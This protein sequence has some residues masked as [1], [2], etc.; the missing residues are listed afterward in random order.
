[1]TTDFF[2]GTD[3]NAAI[4]IQRDGSILTGGF[5]AHASGQ[6][7]FALA[8]YNG[9]TFDV[10]VQDDTTGGLF[11]FSSV[12]GDYIFNECQKKGLV[13]RGRGKLNKT[14]CSIDLKDA[15][16]DRRLDA[17]F[18]SCTNSGSARITTS[19]TF[20]IADADTRKGICAC[21]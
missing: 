17:H 5:A 12:T 14:A 8:R 10:C 9:V 19:R 2:G 7:D 3:G 20:I 21:R 15:Q 13:L 18:S 16:I 1:V 6:V 11:Q 4:A